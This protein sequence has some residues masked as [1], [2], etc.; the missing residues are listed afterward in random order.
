MISPLCNCPHIIRD[1]MPA[2]SHGFGIICAC[3]YSSF[4]VCRILSL[5]RV[6]CCHHWLPIP[7]RRRTAAAL[8]PHCHRRTTATALLL[9]HHSQIATACCLPVTA[10]TPIS[11]QS[12]PRTTT[13][14]GSLTKKRTQLPEALSEI[15]SLKPF[16]YVPIPSP[17]SP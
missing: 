16:L 7:Y 15:Q 10:S 3:A 4:I 17:Y 11:A 1:G 9:L 12:L 2:F 14:K 6:Y 13:H 8:P 5:F